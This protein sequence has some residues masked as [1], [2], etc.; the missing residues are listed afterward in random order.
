M[1]GL[2]QL[3]VQSP[4]HDAKREAGSLIGNDGVSSESGGEPTRPHDER[5]PARGGLEVPGGRTLRSEN[6]VS[7]RVR[8]RG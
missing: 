5:G 1:G 2:L 4:G 6:G 7:A 8:G 3:E